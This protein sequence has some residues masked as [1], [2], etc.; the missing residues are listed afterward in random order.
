MAKWTKGTSTAESSVWAYTRHL[1]TLLPTQIILFLLSQGND[2]V[3]GTDSLHKG[4]HHDASVS[5]NHKRL[6]Y[7]TQNYS[8]CPHVMRTQWQQLIALITIFKKQKFQSGTTK[9]S[10]LILILLVISIFGSIHNDLS[11]QYSHCIGPKFALSK[12]KIV[13][14][15]RNFNTSWSP[16]RHKCITLTNSF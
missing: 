5:H 1:W 12:R 15:A 10:M 2:V 6:W 8:W 14:W 4:C 13:R 16:I 11:I 9:S 7:H 3:I